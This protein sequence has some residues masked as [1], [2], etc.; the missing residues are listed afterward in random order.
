MLER[1]TILPVARL[2]T[3][4]PDLD[5][6]F[7][8]IAVGGISCATRYQL[9]LF[10]FPTRSIEWPCGGIRRI[11]INSFGFGGTNAHIVLDDAYNYFVMNQMNGLHCT[12][13]T[14][15]PYPSCI[16]NACMA[17]QMATNLDNFHGKHCSRKNFRL[18][19][20]PKFANGEAETHDQKEAN[21]H[22]NEQNS[23]VS[24]RARNNPNNHSVANLWQQTLL[25]WSASDEEALKRMI[26]QYSVHYCDEAIAQPGLRN[27]LAHTLAMRRSNMLWRSF[28]ILSPS[29]AP[30]SLQS[31]VSKPY[32]SSRTGLAFVF[33]GQGAQYSGM[34]SQLLLYP[35]FSSTIRKIDALLSGIGSS[36]SIYGMKL[37]PSI[38]LGCFANGIIDQLENRKAINHPRYSQPICTALQIA[39]FELLKDFGIVP[40]VVIGHS[41]GEIAAA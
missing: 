30:K 21:D 31:A 14:L 37:V 28:A 26:K 6:E 25:V 38:L 35:I 12:L 32:R 23:Q 27:K 8:N 16:G 33:T 11:S 22:C 41:S 40:S 9:T 17:D 13:S 7:Y 15:S 4:N 5:N 39:L 29:D 24:E 34:G 10:Q 3:I 18:L 1:G 19:P 2:E 36:W 20:L